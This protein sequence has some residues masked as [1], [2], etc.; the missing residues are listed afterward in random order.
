M[1]AGSIAGQKSERSNLCRKLF[2]NRCPRC[3]NKPLF[4]AGKGLERVKGIEPSTR[5]LGTMCIE[6]HVVQFRVNPFQLM[7]TR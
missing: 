1:R 4:L 7:Q 2:D 3:P 5:S 6:S